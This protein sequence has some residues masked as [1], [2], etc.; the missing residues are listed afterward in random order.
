LQEEGEFDITYNDF[1]KISI[2]T[3]RAKYY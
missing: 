2:K 3:D 1:P